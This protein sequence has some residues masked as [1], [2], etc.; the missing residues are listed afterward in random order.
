MQVTREPQ[1]LLGDR[2]L[3]TDLPGPVDL[4]AE[5]ERP[6]RDAAG[7]DEQTSPEGIGHRRPQLERRRAGRGRPGEDDAQQ[8]YPPQHRRQSEGQSADQ[9]KAHE[10]VDFRVTATPAEPGEGQVRG[11]ESSK[12]Q[13]SGNRDQAATDRGA[14]QIP[15]DCRAE[16]EQVGRGVR[17]DDEQE[18]HGTR[19]DRPPLLDGDQC[20]EEQLPAAQRVQRPAQ[21]DVEAFGSA[22]PEPPARDGNHGGQPVTLLNGGVPSG[23]SGA[24]PVHRLPP[25][26]AG[27]A[28]AVLRART[29]PPSSL[30]SRPAWC[31][32]GQVAATQPPV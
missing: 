7:E 8:W 3:R 9:H 18:Q 27:R 19:D 30:C 6:H 10:D 32:T 13:G 2:Q 29:T 25:R 28:P 23:T 4:P 11:K 15:V 17:G 24:S 16:E 21:G 5:A 1:P 22:A 12:G 20:S 26:P 14:G 31:P